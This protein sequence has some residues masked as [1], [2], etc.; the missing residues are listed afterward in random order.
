[1]TAPTALRHEP[2]TVT[3]RVPSPDA[4][5]VDGTAHRRGHRRPARRV[6]TRARRLWRLG[7]ITVAVALLVAPMIPVVITAFADVWRYPDL[8]PQQ[9]G[10]SGWRRAFAGGAGEAFLTSFG[11]GVI[12]AGLATS[13]GAMAG[14]SLALHRRRWTPAA[15]VVIALPLAL[16]PYAIAMGMTS[17]VLALRVPSIAAIIVILTAFALPYTTLVA[18]AGYLAYEREFEDVAR[19]LG[20]SRR[21]VWW[22]VRVRLMAPVFATAAFL[23][24]LVSWSDYIVTL[25]IS[26]GTVKTLPQ[27]LAAAQ[28]GTGNA[29]TVAV[30]AIITT[31]P[32]A[33]LL[34]SSAAINRRAS[35]H[36]H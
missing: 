21:M 14:R 34:I 15:I 19:T 16:P 24:F 5:A 3:A 6:E 31:V 22:R 33:L 8:L 4:R 13:L 35:R 18:R 29:S 26:G 23:A 10:W 2:G 9:W 27:A 30:L 7:A 1:M 36:D 20:A 11:I 12:V 28:S 17:T 32:P 25:L